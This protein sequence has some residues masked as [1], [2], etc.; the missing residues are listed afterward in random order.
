MNIFFIIDL[1][2]L[3]SSKSGENK[4]QKNTQ[5]LQKKRKRK[6]YLKKKKS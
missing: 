5:I 4:I 3:L 2:N 1:N 6:N